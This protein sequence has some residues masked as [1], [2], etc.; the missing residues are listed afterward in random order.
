MTMTMML[1]QKISHLLALEHNLEW[2]QQLLQFFWAVYYLWRLFCSFRV[3]LISRHYNT[4]TTRMQVKWVIKF[5]QITTHTYEALQVVVDLA[6]VTYH[7][8][9]LGEALA[10]AN[11]L[12]EL[13]LL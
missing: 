7:K 9:T 3:I 6:Q 10:K 4:L 12:T 11:L 8:A 13:I 2:L 5:N 1:F